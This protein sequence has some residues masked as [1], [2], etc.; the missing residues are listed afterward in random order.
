MMISTFDSLPTPMKNYV[1]TQLL[2][3]CPFSS[4]QFVSSLILPS[5]KRD[6]IALVP[7]ELSYQIIGYLDLKTLGR[8]QR[9]SRAW[10]ELW[11]AKVQS[12]PSGRGA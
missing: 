12:Y 5:L 3:R 6:Y 11:M 8:C 4:L 2:K 7:V 10:R 1:M 9:V